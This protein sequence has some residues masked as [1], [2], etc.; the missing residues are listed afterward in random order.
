MSEKRRLQYIKKQ[1]IT[2]RYISITKREMTSRKLGKGLGQAIQKQV[3]QLVNKNI[4]RC[5]FSLVI[6]QTLIKNRIRCYQSR[7]SKI[8]EIDKDLDWLEFSYTVAGCG[9]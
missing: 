7:M 5:S 9:I 6:R 4:N 3:E 8:K 2:K 1:Y